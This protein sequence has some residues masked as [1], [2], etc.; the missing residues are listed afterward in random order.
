M[1]E[2]KLAKSLHSASKNL[3]IM[4]AQVSFLYQDFVAHKASIAA[5]AMGISGTIFATSSEDSDIN[6]Y[7]LGSNDP[8]FTFKDL[9]KPATVLAFSADDTML[10]AGTYSGSLRL[11]DLKSGTNTWAF[12]A[13]KSCVSALAFTIS[14]LFLAT[15]SLD[16]TVRVWDLENRTLLQEVNT[17][18]P[19][20]IMRSD[21][22][23]VPQIS[24]SVPSDPTVTALTFAPNGSWLLIGNTT[25]RVL[26]WSTSKTRILREFFNVAPRDAVLDASHAPKDAAKGL[27]YPMTRE[28][29]RKIELH[30]IERVAAVCD[31]S[32][33]VFWDLETY[34]ELYRSAVR[35]HGYTDALFPDDGT[36]CVVV[37]QRGIDCVDYTDV[38]NFI[39]GS[40]DVAFAG[41]HGSALRSTSK[42]P[43]LVSLCTD[44]T[45][46]GAISIWVVS[47]K[48]VEPFATKYGFSA[49]SATLKP[50]QLVPR[51]QAPQQPPA[52]VTPPQATK[53]PPTGPHPM[54]FR[55]KIERYTPSTAPNDSY[56]AYDF[57][58]TY[59]PGRVNPQVASNDLAKQMLLGSE[60]T[61]DILAKRVSLV[62][63]FKDNWLTCRFK[64]AIDLIV[65]EPDLRMFCDCITTVDL[66]AGLSIEDATL[67]IA[68]LTSCI[69]E[70]YRCQTNNSQPDTV[71][72]V[73]DAVEIAVY[74]AKVFSQLI[75]S[76]FATVDDARGNQNIVLDERR[77]K[78]N[79]FFKQ[80]CYLASQIEELEQPLKQT[81]LKGL[82]R[83]SLIQMRELG[84]DPK[85]A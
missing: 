69:V 76:T 12:A 66:C 41:L 4:A 81:Q 38:Q 53:P 75:S 27:P 77:D 8:I 22:V 83:H 85:Y 43:Q 45:C 48:Y 16:G 23:E 60:E 57:S 72:I 54:G 65:N 35:Q 73:T 18:V 37:R 79:R 29:I 24:T 36:P 25:G 2:G 46:K 33:I 31:N 82:V 49:A 63:K 10:A 7:K 26:V 44:N 28:T 6:I 56:A 19:H 11:F 39:K 15:G 40:A 32:R 59:N 20:M 62:T 34:T 42:A 1:R 58:A 64:Q 51:Q 5:C 55:A 50:E 70:G 30:P 52:Q 13:H 14:G 80:M 21:D 68:P 61:K 67:L 17:A 84:Y 71:S 78:C 9:G 74:I 3:T 47:L